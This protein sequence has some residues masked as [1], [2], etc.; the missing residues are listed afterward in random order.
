MTLTLITSQPPAADIADTMDRLLEI[1]S[2]GGMSSIAIA[3]V[4]RDGCSRTIWSEAPC[5]QSLIGAVAILQ[6]RLVREAIDDE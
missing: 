2:E 6:Q 4:D 1:V 5:V 3:M